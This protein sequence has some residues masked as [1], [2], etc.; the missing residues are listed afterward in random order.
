MVAPAMRV[1]DISGASGR[2][3]EK[4]AAGDSRLGKWPGMVTPAKCG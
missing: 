1:E 2:V 3:T 4:L